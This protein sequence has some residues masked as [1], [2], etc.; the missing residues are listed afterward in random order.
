MVQ[1]LILAR[2]PARNVLR[3][4]KQAKAVRG[5][6]EAFPVF[7]RFDA[8]VWIR[9]R[10]MQGIRDIAREVL[11]IGGIKGTETLLEAD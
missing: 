8:V 5:V 3:F 10:D 6:V 2:V 9:A 7:G 11:D 4:V 1:E